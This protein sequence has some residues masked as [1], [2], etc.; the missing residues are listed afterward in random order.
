MI[1]Y[2]I[3]NV[4]NGKRYIGQTGRAF[5]LRKAH[6]LHYLRSGKH[7]SRYLQRAFDKDAYLKKYY[8][9]E[10]A[11]NDSQILKGEMG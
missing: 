11:H 7:G 8:A 4:V 5:Y 2:Q 1:I 9:L 6:H 10:K 3:L